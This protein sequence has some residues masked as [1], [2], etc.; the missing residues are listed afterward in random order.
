MSKKQLGGIRQK[1]R[2]DRKQQ[3]ILPAK[4]PG[5]PAGTESIANQLTQNQGRKPQLSAEKLG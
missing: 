2:K 5:I 4:A 3:G 1:E